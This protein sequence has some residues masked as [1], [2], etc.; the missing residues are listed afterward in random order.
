M[1]KPV[2]NIG[3]FLSVYL[4]LHPDMSQQSL[5]KKFGI[6]QV[7]ISRIMRGT[8][9]GNALI[10]NPVFHEMLMSTDCD[11]LMDDIRKIS[12]YKKSVISTERK[13]ALERVLRQYVERK[14]GEESHF[15]AI[16]TNDK[17]CFTVITPNGSRW[18]FQEI[19]DFE[20]KEVYPDYQADHFILFTTSN[21]P[22]L[23]Q[24]GSA[25][26]SGVYGLLYGG[27]L[28]KGQKI[29]AM[30]IDL[31]REAVISECSLIK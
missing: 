15:V 25:I 10:E 27:T 29:S 22:K 11:A 12:A 21:M 26:V 14:T 23:V 13:A 9:S 17:H 18:L 3:R 2:I 24:N 20:S 28:P 4:M 6:G 19:Q 1:N 5:A 31:E 7:T 30:L 16:T 8:S